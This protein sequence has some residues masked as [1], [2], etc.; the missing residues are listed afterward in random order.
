MLLKEGIIQPSKSPWSTPL[1][2]VAK[3]GNGWRPCG[4]YRRLNAR[5]IPDRYPIP[6]IE[7]FA[8]TLHQKT[9]FTTLDLVRAYNQI[10]VLEE[11]IPKTEITTPFGLFEFLYMPFGLSNAAQTFQR[12]IN[13]VLHGLD[14]C[15]A[16]ID[17]ILVASTNQQK[18]GK[19]LQ[20][21]FSR[22]DEYGVK[23]NPTKCV[24]GA[25][26]VKF[27]GYHVSAKGTK[28]IPEKIKAIQNFPK[29]VNAKQLRQFLGTINFYRR[30]IPG[31]AKN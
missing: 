4:D 26:W 3:K 31:K 30:F 27:L 29:P 21:L 1:H 25:K 16:Y 7:D 2:M 20:Q 15:Y 22:L 14:F 17:D 10:P 19:H 9:V 13:K 8:Q 23:I 11:D 6:H 12:F 28:P 24:F 18:H 5:T